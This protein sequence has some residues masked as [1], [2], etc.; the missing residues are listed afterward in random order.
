LI[1][2]E[3]I[4]VVT[5]SILV[6]ISPLGHLVDEGVCQTEWMGQPDAVRIAV[7]VAVIV[8]ATKSVLR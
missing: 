4:P 8:R 1:R 2:L 3:A 7:T 6:C 5:E